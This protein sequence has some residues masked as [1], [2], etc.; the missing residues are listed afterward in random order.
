MKSWYSSKTIWLAVIQAVLGI[1]AAI[2]VENPSL[3]DVGVFL[4]LKSVLDIGLRLLTTCEIGS[5]DQIDAV[6]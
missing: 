6:L 1:L 5:R 2:R 4:I 3:F